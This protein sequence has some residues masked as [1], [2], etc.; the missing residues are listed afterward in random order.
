MPALCNII[1]T[2]LI[3]LVLVVAVM[4]VYPKG[5]GYQL[6]EV[7]S[8]SMEPAIPM[9]SVVYVSE[10]DAK[11]LEAGEVIAFVHEQDFV[12]HRVVENNKLEGYLQTKGDANTVDDPW[13]VRYEDV[14]GVV[15]KH[16][17]VI[18]RFL[19]LVSGTIGKIYLLA[20]GLCG[21]LANVLASLIRRRRSTS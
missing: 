21:V 20:I 7:T 3:L 8:G 10:A 12:I 9:G 4:L 18:G 14:L 1:G 16:Y 19:G 6:F 13:K 17:P 15:A 2:L 11:D 5:K